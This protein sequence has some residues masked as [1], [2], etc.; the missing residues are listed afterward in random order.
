MKKGIVL[1]ISFLLAVYLT[2]FVS[3]VRAESIHAACTH[4]TLTVVSDSNT[5]ADGNPAVPTSP[6]NYAFS[7][8]DGAT[9]IWSV[10]KVSSYD[11]YGPINFTRTIDLPSNAQNIQ[12]SIQIGADNAFELYINGNYVGGRGIVRQG[13]VDNQDPSTFGVPGTTVTYNVNLKTGQNNLLVPAVNYKIYW[14]DHADPNTNPAGI[15][16]RLDTAYDIC[17]E[18]LTG[19]GSSPRESTLTQTTIALDKGYTATTRETLVTYSTESG[20]NSI[21]LSSL[22][23]MVVAYLIGFIG[24]IISIIV[25][26]GTTLKEILSNQTSFEELLVAIVGIIIVEHYRKKHVEEIDEKLTKLLE[27]LSQN[28]EK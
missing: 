26:A 11:E 14:M 13:I 8:L 23:N 28:K 4:K 10:Y 25:I 22:I 19:A 18:G 3:V 5:L 9:W 21:N 7:S 1:L 24:G 2:S 20:E 15:A 17:D 6:G 16:Y 12:A 27:K